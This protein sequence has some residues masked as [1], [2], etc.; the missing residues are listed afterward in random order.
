MLEEADFEAGDGLA[1]VLAGEGAVGESGEAGE[2]VAAW[3]SAQRLNVAA[4]AS[5]IMGRNDE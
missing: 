5:Q 1:D 3:T 2:V 4:K